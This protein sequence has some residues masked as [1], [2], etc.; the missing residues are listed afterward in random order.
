MALI[1]PENG[2]KSVFLLQR[3]VNFVYHFFAWL[4]VLKERYIQLK[5][6]IKGISHITLPCT[7]ES[8]NF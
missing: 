4:F 7:V 3:E 8:Y 5:K 6:K 1:Q 2:P